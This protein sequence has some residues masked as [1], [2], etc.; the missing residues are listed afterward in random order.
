MKLQFGNQGSIVNQMLK[1]PLEQMSRAEK[2]MAMEA[3]WEN[4]SRDDAA[5]ESPPWHAEVLAATE[6][7]V[8]A[9]QE[10]FVDWEAA[11]R[12]LRKR[13]G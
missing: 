9:G 8:A 10:Q 6:K 11:R 7:R 5:L 2:I 4:L 13:L 1:L 12:Q 3:L